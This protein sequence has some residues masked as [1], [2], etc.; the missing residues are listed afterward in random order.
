MKIAPF[1]LPSNP[2]KTI[3]LREATVEDCEYFAETDSDSEEMMTNEVMDLLQCEPDKYVDPREWTAD[4]RR[5]A[6][7]WYFIATNEDTTIHAPYNCPHC[8]EDHDPLVEMKDIGKEYKP[9]TGRP[10]RE[11][12]HEG[13][14]LR[15]IP[16]NGYLMT[17]L[18]SIRI[19]SD[20]SDTERRKNLAIME[21]HDIVGTL[22]EGTEPARDYRVAVIEKWV[23]SLSISSFKAL[24]EKRN[25][26]LS[27]MAHGLPT[28]LHEGKLFIMTTVHCENKL[29]D[30]GAKVRLRL[31]FW[32]GEMLPRLL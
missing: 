11:I 15:V 3:Y 8:N 6:A 25:N 26:A 9:I 23:R 1:Q 30:A 20:G 22:I 32:L 7:F 2:E 13:K 27:E 5:L 12:E 4:D 18:E 16:R 28:R 17:E 21:R 24:K 29:E 19:Q 31:P 14:K 10:Y